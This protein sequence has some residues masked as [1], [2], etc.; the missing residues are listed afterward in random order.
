MRKHQKEMD[1]NYTE[2]SKKTKT[3]W[4]IKQENQ[5]IF[6]Q[7]RKQEDGQMHTDHGLTEHFTGTE[8]ALYADGK[9]KIA[10]STR[11]LRSVRAVEQGWWMMRLIDADALIKMTI[12]NPDHVPYIT[13]TDVEDTPTIELNRLEWEELLVI[14]D[15]CGHAIHVTKE[16]AHTIE[17]E[18]KKGKWIWV[19]Y[20]ANPEIGNWH[21]SECRFMP[22]AFNL[23]KKHLNYCPNCG[24]KMMEE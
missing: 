8:H 4:N 24:A 17:P 19:Q 1:G 16:D 10:T 5:Q 14:C 15:N 18:R 21:C 13:R 2:S 22:S 20:D 9:G 3:R 7:Q 23:A 11:I 6:R 12:L